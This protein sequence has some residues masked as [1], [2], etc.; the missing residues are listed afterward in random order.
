MKFR[1]GSRVH[2]TKCNSLCS[3]ECWKGLCLFVW[4][5]QPC[6]GKDKAARH[7]HRKDCI[8][9]V[10]HPESCCS[11]F[12]FFFLVSWDN[13]SLWNFCIL[14]FPRETW[15]VCTQILGSW[16]KEFI[17]RENC[18][19]FLQT[20]L[21]PKRITCLIYSSK[22]PANKSHRA[23]CGYQRSTVFSEEYGVH[24]SFPGGGHPGTSGAHQLLPQQ[25]SKGR[26][27][28]HPHKEAWVSEALFSLRTVRY[29]RE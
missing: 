10:T 23:V 9:R 18:P 20:S 8:Y 6:W 29:T 11:F 13:V 16:T 12:F 2:R 19:T 5:P 17:L 3:L 4:A 14:S 1:V 28:Q 24:Q 27:K 22:P 26:G 25:L 15:L 21:T 7:V